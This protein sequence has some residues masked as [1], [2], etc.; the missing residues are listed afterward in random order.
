MR[1]GKLRV[2]SAKVDVREK[3]RGQR[4]SSPVPGLMYDGLR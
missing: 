2:T 1:R 4:L 3:K